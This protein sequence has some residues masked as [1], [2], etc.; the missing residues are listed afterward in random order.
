[1]NDQKEK[2]YKRI[3]RRLAKE[4]KACACGGCACRKDEDCEIWQT[5]NRAKKIL[6]E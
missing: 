3:I 6:K 1:M 5:L 4:L 2:R